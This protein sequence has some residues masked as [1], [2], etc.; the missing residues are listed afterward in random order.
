VTVALEGG[1]AVPEASSGAMIDGDVR[2]R[3]DNSNAGPYFDFANN[4]AIPNCVLNQVRFW[5]RAQTKTQCCSST[6][7][8]HTLAPC[9]GSALI[10][11]KEP[12]CNSFCTTLAKLQTRMSKQS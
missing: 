2:A 9:D 3:A 12:A 4:V 8:R 10:R 7:V 6:T 1:T 5:A 11:K